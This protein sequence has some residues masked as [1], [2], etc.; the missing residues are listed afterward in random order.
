MAFFMPRCL[1]IF[2][3]HALSQDHFA[4]RAHIADA[5]CGRAIHRK[6]IKCSDGDAVIDRK[7]WLARRAGRANNSRP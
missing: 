2:I 4:A 1:A 5:E 7:E 6:E 3:A